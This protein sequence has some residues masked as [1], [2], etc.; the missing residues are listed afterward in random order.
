MSA[1]HDYAGVQYEERESSDI[2]AGADEKAVS[3]STGSTA[4]PSPGNPVGNPAADRFDWGLKKETEDSSSVDT[5]TDQESDAVDVP[6]QFD[7]AS[8]PEPRRREETHQALRQWE[9]VVEAVNDDEFEARLSA[10]DDPTVDDEFVTLETARVAQD[11]RSLIEP[12]AVF[13]WNIGE[14]H[15]VDGQLRN[16]SEIRFRRLPKRTKRDLE[17]ATEEASDFKAKLFGREPE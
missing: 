4:G 1:A 5:S 11:D 14:T 16:Y 10:L 13:Y 2:G 8:M 9:G 7:I 3:E 17:R 6:D 12:G 15:T